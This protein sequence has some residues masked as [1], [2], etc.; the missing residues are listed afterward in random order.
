MKILNINSYLK[1]IVESKISYEETPGVLVSTTY[2]N[3]FCW[4]IYGDTIFSYKVKIC[5]LIGSIITITLISIY[6]IYE[7]RKYTLDA[8]LNV[9]I[10]ITGSY[11]TYHG[12]IIFVDD[13]AVIQ[14]PI[15][16]K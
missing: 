3:C 11:A 14:I 13:D 9:L 1:W 7:I 10:I 12:L 4:Y 2:I 6:F 5:N 8:I 16:N 15:P